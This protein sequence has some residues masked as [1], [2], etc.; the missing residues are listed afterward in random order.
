MDPQTAE[1]HAL[2]GEHTY[3]AAPGADVFAITRINPDWGLFEAQLLRYRDGKPESDPLLSFQSVDDLTRP[4]SE[5]VRADLDGPQTSLLDLTSNPLQPGWL[6]N[7]FI[8]AGLIEQGR[9]FAMTNGQYYPVETMHG[10]DKH[11]AHII[12]LN[13]T[14]LRDTEPYTVE[15]NEESLSPFELVNKRLCERIGT[16]A[17]LVTTADQ[18]QRVK[19]ELFAAGDTLANMA[20]MRHSV[21]TSIGEADDHQIHYCTEEGGDSLTIHNDSANESIELTGHEAH[22]FIHEAAA[23]THDTGLSMDLCMTYTAYEYAC[24]DNAPSLAQ[25]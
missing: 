13:H 6:E 11:C 17:E 12:D 10:E 23:L 4:L 25:E 16:E 24:P 8:K 9:P 21:L 19:D 1:S 3:S 7:A 2:I 20:R 5:L 14:R 15:V 18:W 22:Q